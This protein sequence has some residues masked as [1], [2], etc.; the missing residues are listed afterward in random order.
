MSRLTAGIAALASRPIPAAILTAIAVTLFTTLAPVSGEGAGFLW[1]ELWRYA[2]SGAPMLFSADGYLFLDYVQKAAASGDFGGVPFFAL[3]A[4]VLARYLPVSPETTAFFLPLLFTGVL[5]ALAFAWTRKGGA[6]LAASLAGMAACLLSPAFLERSGAGWFDTD[7]AIAVCWFGLLYCLTFLPHASSCTKGDTPPAPGD[8]RGTAHPAL[9]LAGTALCAVLLALVWLPGAGLA[10]LAL[11][12][13][14]VLPASW[15]GCPWYGTRTR[16]ILTPALLIASALFLL[17]PDAFLPAA[18]AAARNYAFDHFM[19]VF[20]LK[21]GTVYS[22]IAEL[23]SLDSVQWL[24]KL[25]GYAPGGVLLLLMAVVAFAAFPF[26]RL[27][28]LVSAVFLAAGFGA[29]RFVY[30]GALVPALS[31]GLFPDAVVRLRKVPRS[32]QSAAKHTGKTATHDKRGTSIRTAGALCCLAFLLSCAAWTVSRSYTIY[33]EQ[34]HDQ[35]ARTLHDTAPKDA[36]LW[37]WWDDGYYLRARTGR[38]PLFDG[39]SQTAE[40]AFIAA[41]PLLADN[42]LFAKR[43]MRFFALRGPNALAALKKAWGSEAAVANLEMLFSSYNPHTVL[44]HLPPLSFTKDAERW[45]FP[46]GTVYLY[47]PRRF[48]SLSHAWVPSGA[49]HISPEELSYSHIHDISADGIVYDAA[50]GRLRL[51]PS[52]QEKG[53]TRFGAILITDERPLNSPWP[54]ESGPYLIYTRSSPKAVVAN[55]IGVRTMAVRLFMSGPYTVPGFTPLA[56]DPAWGGVWE[57]TP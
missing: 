26:M 43:W 55:E 28:L 37:N 3:P 23:D 31:V 44:A 45:L 17:L 7:P 13:W 57:V 46:E 35:F 5:A 16:T 20:G 36:R 42:A 18:A 50:A 41:R 22:S 47:L 6:G 21:E 14:L 34:P 32:A 12:A 39:G 30:I 2:D 33:W 8:P 19:L 53:Y 10:L 48:L 54:E 15:G 4:A 1:P 56:F 29:E 24:T 11:G 9:Y 40:A 38:A 52:L 27:A 49:P 25:G 51:P